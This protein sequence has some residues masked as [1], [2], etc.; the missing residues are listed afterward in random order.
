VSL[1]GYVYGA[2]FLLARGSVSR[3]EQRLRPLREP[4]PEVWRARRR[5]YRLWVALLVP[6]LPV[7][8][9]AVNLSP[10]HLESLRVRFGGR[11]AQVTLVMNVL[12]LALFIGL[13]AVY[14]LPPLVADYRGDPVLRSELTRLRQQL[15]RGRPRAVFF[16]GVL[17]ALGLMALLLW[18]RPQR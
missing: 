7:L 15:G 12:A 3:P 4:E 13:F 17:A 18:I 6:V 11:T 14:F 9:H 2:G 1:V 5:F 10:S 8:V 16:L